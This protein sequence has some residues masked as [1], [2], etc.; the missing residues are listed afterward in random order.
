MTIVTVDPITNVQQTQVLAYT[1]GP[2]M[3]AN[4]RSN[5]FNAKNPDTENTESQKSFTMRLR[6][7]WY[8]SYAL[9]A[10]DFNMLTID[11]FPV[12]KLNTLHSL[13]SIVITY[14]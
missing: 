5:Y 2:F 13:Y 3:S 14:R 6:G 10:P 12:G 9:S 8:I 7:G 4:A 1:P 11:L